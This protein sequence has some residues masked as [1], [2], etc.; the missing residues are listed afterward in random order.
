MPKRDTEGT[1]R[2]ADVYTKLRHITVKAKQEPGL[3]FTSLAHLLNE[4][5][6]SDSCERLKKEASAGIDG[7]TWREYAADRERLLEALL[8]R[9]KAGTYRAQPVRRVYIEKEDG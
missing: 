2:P 7:V 4:Q 9:L 5:M 3:A 6:L 8:G 1:Q